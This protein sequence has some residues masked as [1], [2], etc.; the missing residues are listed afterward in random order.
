MLHEKGSFVVYIF[1]CPITDVFFTGSDILHMVSVCGDV[2]LETTTHTVGLR[3]AE[4]CLEFR[5]F[6]VQVYYD[7]GVVI[8]V[9]KERLGEF[10]YKREYITGEFHTCVY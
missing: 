4:F 10:A 3:S 8:T 6:S 5:P 1:A 7:L 9:P 2:G